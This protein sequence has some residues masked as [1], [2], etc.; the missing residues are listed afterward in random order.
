MVKALFARFEHV[1]LGLRFLTEMS[2]VCHA[3]TGNG[4]TR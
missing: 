1:H 4:R 2:A 3:M